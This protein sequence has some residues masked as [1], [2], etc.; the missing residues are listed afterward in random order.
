MTRT[1]SD[2][3]HVLQGDNNPGDDRALYERGRRWLQQ[4]HLIGRAVAFLPRVGMVTIVM[5]DYPWVKYTVMGILAV[6]CLL[7]L[8]E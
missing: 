5:N 2:A 6:V 7:G 4:E 3:A 1:A 8:D